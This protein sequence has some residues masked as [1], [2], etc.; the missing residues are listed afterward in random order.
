MSSDLGPN[1]EEIL[2]GRPLY[3]TCAR[4]CEADS[5]RAGRG[6]LGG[7]GGSPSPFRYCGT[8]E[9]TASPNVKHAVSPADEPRTASPA[10]PTDGPTASPTVEPAVSP[11]DEPTASP[12]V[13][14]TASPTDGPTAS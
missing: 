5:A 9:P 11:T 14:P 13:E 1:R 6:R 7:E 3:L 4:R 10:S 12:A 2:A 8:D